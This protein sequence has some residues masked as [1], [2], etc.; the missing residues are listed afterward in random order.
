M[1]AVVKKPNPRN[2]DNANH[3]AEVRKSIEK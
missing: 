3:V 2:I 1:A